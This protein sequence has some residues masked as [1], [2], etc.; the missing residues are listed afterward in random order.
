[1]KYLKFTLFSVVIVALISGLILYRISTR[2]PSK[3]VIAAGPAGGNYYQL[4]AEIA[5]RLQE[6]L[7]TKVEVLE[8]QGALDNL[9]RIQDGIVDFAL[10]QPDTAR[11]TNESETP[12]SAAFVANLYSEVLHIFAAPGSG[13]ETAGDLKGKKIA[14][15][16]RESGD[17]SLNKTL[18]EHLGIS[19]DEIELVDAVYQEIPDLLR[20]GKLDAACMA[21]GLHSPAFIET[22]KVQGVKLIPVPFADAMALHHVSTFPTRIPA[23]FYR[24]KTPVL[25]ESEIETVSRRAKLLTRPNAP[26]VLVEAVTNV[27]MDEH[28]QRSNELHE[29]FDRGKQFAMANPEFPM[30]PGAEH[31]YNP[32]LK[33]LL[34]PDFVEATEGLRSFLFSVLVAGWLVARWLRDRRLKQDEH[35]LDQFV[36]RVLDIERRQL[37]LDEDESGNDVEQLQLLLDEVTQLRQEALGEF[38]AHSMNEDPSVACFVQMCHA[39]SNKINAKLTRQRTDRQMRTFIELTT[40]HYENMENP[41]KGKRPS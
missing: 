31:I 12:E 16:T 38:N 2:V 24:T 39:L 20:S 32:E 13:I 6:Q 11:G 4:S 40:K 25:P 30:H 3:V 33:P 37:G 10:Y 22:A 27:V 35:E 23:G 14:I 28:F 15:G 34:N 18:L 1:M 36:R 21:G 41:A 29:L 5:E 8:S 17:F 9:H 19:L 7:G 26:T